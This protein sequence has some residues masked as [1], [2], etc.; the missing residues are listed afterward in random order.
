MEHIIYFLNPQKRTILFV[1]HSINLYGAEKSLLDLI[2]NLDSF[3]IIV[4]CPSDGP[5]VDVLRRHKINHLIVPYM[6]WLGRKFRLIKGL[7]RLFINGIA[8]PLILFKL[9][10]VRIDIIYTNT[11]YSP[12][13]SFVAFF[14]QCP[15]IWHIREDVKEMM[16][17]YDF[18]E[19][20]SLNWI[21]KRS[22]KIICNS[23]FIKEKLKLYT[24]PEQ[25]VV[26][27]NG[28][29]DEV[30][31]NKLNGKIRDN[32]SNP[33]QL[34]LVGSLAPH[35][36]HKD[37]LM[38]VSLLRN[39]GMNIRLIIIG[40][41]P[42]HS[43]LQALKE[44]AANLDISDHVYFGGYHNNPIEIFIQ[45][46]ATL[47]CSKLESFGRVAVESISVGCPVIGTNR[48]GLPEIIENMKTGL[49]YEPGDY[50][51]LTEQI[52]KLLTDF[53]LYEMLSKDGILFVYKKFTK[54]RYVEEIQEVIFDIFDK[55]SQS[56]PYSK[57]N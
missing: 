9:R 49:L 5:F 41:S 57:P 34:A 52:I 29:L 2:L 3:N 22:Q 35:K 25:L 48:G 32:I 43:Y 4:L 21:G 39:Q 10:R 56:Q 45:S 11:I 23:Y 40:D 54:R 31:A 28:I 46:D 19:S 36:G 18:G 26:I 51:M 20:C 15:H 16:A 7:F 42:D 14:L 33:I 24:Y 55:N 53:S 12:I 37:A 44:L 13:G 30:D 50:K 38:A 17:N 27:Y 6:G 47:I 1:A 8:V